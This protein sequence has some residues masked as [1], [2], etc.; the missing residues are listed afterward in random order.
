MRPAAHHQSV[1]ELT[2]R[3]SALSL[4]ARADRSASVS[5]GWWRASGGRRLTPVSREHA[6]RA[7]VVEDGALPLGK[8]THT[9]EA[10]FPSLVGLQTVGSRGPRAEPVCIPWWRACR[11]TCFQLDGSKPSWATSKSSP[12]TYRQ[13]IFFAPRAMRA[14]ASEREMGVIAPWSSRSTI[15]T[16]RSSRGTTCRVPRKR[17][18]S[19]RG[20]HMV[21]SWCGA[22]RTSREREKTRKT[23]TEKE[24]KARAVKFVCSTVAKILIFLATI[25][26]R[27][28]EKCG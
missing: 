24:R 2:P 28:N 3:T 5:G 18:G 21:G 14:R 7:G 19:D 8:M 1:G 11:V 13:H 22:R 12:A 20:L 26:A 25:L 9:T 17:S 10:A 15:P 4:R 27:E 23:H 16:R 6:P